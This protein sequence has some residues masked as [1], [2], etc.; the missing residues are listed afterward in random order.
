VLHSV[1]PGYEYVDHL[2]ALYTASQASPLTFRILNMHAWAQLE[3]LSI[4]ET[5]NKRIV[6]REYE[7]EHVKMFTFR[8]LQT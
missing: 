4:Y 6:S 3:M 7:V 5:G 1:S 2:V 8:G